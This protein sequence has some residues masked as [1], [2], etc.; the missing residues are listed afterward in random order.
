MAG[1]TALI[2]KATLA[3]ICTKIGVTPAYL[4]QR[5]GVTEDKISLWL[6]PS[7]QEL[8]TIIQAKKLAK[9][10]HIPFAGL[11]MNAEQIDFGRLPTLRNLRTLPDAG[12]VDDSVLN[13][14]V[15]DLIRAR[16]FWK[17]VSLDLS[18]D[19][20][21]LSLPDIANDAAPAVYAECIRRFFKLDL[22]AQYKCASPRQFYLFVRRQIEAKG[23]FLHCFSDVPVETARGIAI[24]DED[25]PIIGVNEKD[26]PPAKTFTIIHE[27]VHILKRQSAM[28]NDMT[29]FS[30]Q[31][32]EVFCNAVAGEVL[33]PAAALKAYFQAHNL[34]DISL[35]SIK[36]IA[37][38]FSISREVIVRR[39]FDTARFSK[40]E[41][42]TFANELQASFEAEREASKIAQAEGRE[43]PYKRNMTR[44]AIDKTS[45]SMC[46]ILLLG[47][48][49]GYFTKQDVSGLLGIKEKHIPKFVTEVS[50]WIR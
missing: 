47:F 31:Q 19:R 42:D 35:D 6:S 36:T 49:E 24:Y 26:R 25:T 1:T 10:L 8:P 20:V 39:L 34:T 11:Y 33:V 50:K 44:E 30:A 16:D 48:G 17:A 12:S 21:T 28:C 27:L 29:A 2:N 4:A 13:I 38:K 15:V 3:S 40:D 37:D 14:A 23:L 46:K 45:S 43:D 9:I 32:E 22:N 7:S 18:I 5:T 41:Y